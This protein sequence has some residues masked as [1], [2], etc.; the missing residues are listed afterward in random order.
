M[1]KNKFFVGKVDDFRR[2]K[3]WFFG[4]FADNKLLGSDLVEVAWNKLY[5]KQKLDKHVHKKSVEL[6]IIISGAATLMINEK[7]YTVS[8]GEFYVIW[9]ETVVQNIDAKDDTEVIVIRAPSVDDKVVI[10]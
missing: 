8:K 1:N 9:P 5:P 4:H 3:G 10:K 2:N 7:E 6:N